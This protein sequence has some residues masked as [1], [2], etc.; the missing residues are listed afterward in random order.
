M[1][2]RFLS[3]N[4]YHLLLLSSGCHAC[5]CTLEGH[6]HGVSVQSS[7][8]LGKSFLRK[9][10]S[11]REVSHIWKFAPTWILARVFA[12]LPPFVSK[13]I[14]SGWRDSENQQ[15]KVL[16]FH[17]VAYLTD[18]FRRRVITIINW[19]IFPQRTSFSDYCDL[20]HLIKDHN[21]KGSP[22]FSIHWI[23]S[24]G[25]RTLASLLRET[26]ADLGESEH[27]ETA[28]PFFC[29]ILHHF[30]TFSSKIDNLYKYIPWG[31]LHLPFTSF[32][33][34]VPILTAWSG[35]TLYAE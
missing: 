27:R 20:R 6:Q 1:N 25:R 22:L 9:Y 23:W 19:G 33:P 35:V 5:W 16:H 12:Y 4:R 28:L 29:E 2:S 13:I 31:F 34:Y 30:Q 15:L 24:W 8:N 10:I 7:I 18:T 11:P 21:R 3:K 26:S 32:L 17:T 14:D